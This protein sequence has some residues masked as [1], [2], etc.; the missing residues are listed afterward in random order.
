[1][2]FI[3][4]CF[5]SLLL[6]SYQPAVKMPTTTETKPSTT[7]RPSTIIKPTTIIKPITTIII[8]TTT[9]INPLSQHPPSSPQKSLSLNSNYSTAISLSS[10]LIPH[11][12]DT[13]THHINSYW[14]PTP[15]R[16]MR[17]PYA[18]SSTSCLF[19]C[20]SLSSKNTLPYLPHPLKAPVHHRKDNVRDYCAE[21]ARGWDELR[22][23]R[24]EDGE[25]E[26]GRVDW[27][28]VGKGGR[29][30]E[31]DGEEGEG[32]GEEEGEEKEEEEKK[33]EEEDNNKDKEEDEMIKMIDEYL[34]S[35]VFFK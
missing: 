34:E 17:I 1:M 16:P 4:S 28:W 32:D 20:C 15:T 6:K 27:T 11:T 12:S 9:I 19:S 22:R 10:S 18:R 25:K 13:A 33:E 3:Y 24:V 14:D 31:S 30:Q 26:V 21:G 2:A 5:P 29:G 35:R 7:I 23:Q 8:P